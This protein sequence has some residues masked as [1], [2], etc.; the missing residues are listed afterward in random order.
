MATNL[1]ARLGKKHVVESEHECVLSAGQRHVEQAF[2]FLAILAFEQL[3]DFVGCVGQIEKHNR[4]AGLADFEETRVTWRSR[5]HV[6]G[7]KR[8]DHRLPLRAFCF[9]RRDQLNRV[10]ARRTDLA[11]IGEMGPQ[12]FGKLGQ[13]HALGFGRTRQREQCIQLAIQIFKIISRQRIQPFAQL[14]PAHDFVDRVEQR[15][16]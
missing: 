16:H 1:A 15:Q 7:E 2:H 11:R 8:N 10:R 3:L 5:A 12:M 4:F 14:C 13:G 9:L 6:A